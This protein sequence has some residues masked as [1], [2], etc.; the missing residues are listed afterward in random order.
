MAQ[1]GWASV[2]ATWEDTGGQANLYANGQSSDPA[3]V[4]ATVS[5]P[6]DLWLGST[7]GGGSASQAAMANLMIYSQPMSEEQALSQHRAA[8]WTDLH[9]QDEEEY[10]V[11]PLTID[12][13]YDPLYRLTSASY[14]SGESYN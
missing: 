10:V 8:T 11:E 2:V 7:A 13:G 12:Y 14:S 1:G 3:V 4:T 5:A 9:P 6:L